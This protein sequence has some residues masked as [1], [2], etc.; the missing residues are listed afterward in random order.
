MMELQI[1]RIHRSNLSTSKEDKEA[2][3]FIAA[4][5]IALGFGDQVT[6]WMLACINSLP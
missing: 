6:N 5:T 2:F 4:R 1:H 3:R